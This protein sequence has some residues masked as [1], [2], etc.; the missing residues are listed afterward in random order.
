[1]PVCL[2][3]CSSA[4]T[5]SNHP[6]FP[7]HVNPPLAGGWGGEDESVRRDR[8]AVVS[9]LVEVRGVLTSEQSRRMALEEQL[10]EL[11]ETAQAYKEQ[12]GGACSFPSQ[13]LSLSL[14]RFQSLSQSRFQSLS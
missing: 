2:C 9:Q 14:S 10:V 3:A 13:S 8:D 7:R 1:M 12:V 11:Q 5:G 4:K 6:F